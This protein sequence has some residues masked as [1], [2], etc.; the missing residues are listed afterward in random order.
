MQ[1]ENSLFQNFLTDLKKVCRFI[2]K[3]AREILL[4]VIMLAA[5]IPSV[6]LRA[7]IDVEGLLKT[8]VIIYLNMFFIY[9]VCTLMLLSRKYP[10]LSKVAA[11][12]FMLAVPILA[13][14]MQ[15]G[16][17]DGVQMQN[18]PQIIAFN[19]LFVYIVEAVLLLITFSPCAAASL[20]VVF[21]GLLGLAQCMVMQFRSLPIMPWDM[22][23]FGTALSVVGDYKLQLDGRLTWLIIGFMIFAVG[24]VF[25][26]REKIDLK[27][28]LRD[29]IIVRI[30]F[31]VLCITM[32]MGYANV[33][34][35]DD[36]QDDV[37]YY[38]YLFTPKPLYKYNGFYFS[39]VSLLKYMDVDAPSGYDHQ[40]LKQ[41][42]EGIADGQPN[43][44]ED[45][46][47]NIIVI[48]NESFSDLSIYGDI[49]LDMS[50]T[51]NID[52]LVENTVKGQAYVSVK[53]GN[54]PNSEWEFL[55]G[56]T[57]AFLPSGSVPYQQYLRSDTEN[58]LSTLKTKG[59]KAYSIHP[60]P[61]SGW[62]R[63]TVYPMLGIDKR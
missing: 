29:K 14:V 46:K 23:S 58:L 12:V 30:L 48:M 31:I 1:K 21:C 34:Q 8:D 41:T 54:T 55:T 9:L 39:F 52:S 36:F 32:I 20:T 61:A 15:E 49:G 25:F 5:P 33:A 4:I 11:A 53:G 60:Y 50:Y 45:V 16:F 18:S 3:W 47:P 10:I 37:R 63:D 2:E 22:L 35:S 17:V 57:M 28:G 43:E 56:D 24:A 6:K 7:F 13:Y 19:I 26:C 27:L 51:P 42:A 44:K 38:P 59:Y 40:K 62:D